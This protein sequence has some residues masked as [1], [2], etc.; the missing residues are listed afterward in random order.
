MLFFLFRL[1]FVLCNTCNLALRWSLHF[2]CHGYNSARFDHHGIIQALI[3]MHRKRVPY[4]SNLTILPRTNET[5]ISIKMDLFCDVCHVIDP[6]T[7]NVTK[8]STKIPSKL[9]WINVPLWPAILC[10]TENYLF[11][12]WMKNLRFLDFFNMGFDNFSSV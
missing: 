10:D 1:R 6:Q 5:Y 7:G 2:R 3:S 9:V 4:Y 11:L 8:K 12:I